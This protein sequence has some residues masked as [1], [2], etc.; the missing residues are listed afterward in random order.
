MNVAMAGVWMFVVNGLAACMITVKR[1]HL[2]TDE[3]EDYTE[4]VN[5]ISSDLDIHNASEQ[6]EL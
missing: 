6:K 3:S 5:S 4:Q 2:S 1:I